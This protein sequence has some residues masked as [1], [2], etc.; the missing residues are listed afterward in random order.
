MNAGRVLTEAGVDTEQLRVLIHPIQPEQVWLRSATAVMMRFWGAGIQ[1]MT[2]RRWI[3]VDPR[4]LNGD[5]AKLSLLIIHELVHV[6]QWSDLGVIGFLSSYLGSY[7]RGRRDGL[8][9][10]DSYRAI[11]LEV[12]AREIQARFR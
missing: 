3:F 1:A 7:L 10:R 4:L 12:E 8:N 11:D 9:H 2:V 6:R 5:T